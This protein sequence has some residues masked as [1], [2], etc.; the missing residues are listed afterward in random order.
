MTE[1]MVEK[2]E[3][4]K[5]LYLNQLEKYGG[6]PESF[7]RAFDLYR[8]SILSSLVMWLGAL[9]PEDEAPQM[10]PEDPCLEFITRMFQAW[11]DLDVTSSFN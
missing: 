1:T 10:Q 9:A 8:M 2:F 6:K 7:S 5:A 4:V 3:R 11:E